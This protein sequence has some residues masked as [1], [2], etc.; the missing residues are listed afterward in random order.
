MSIRKRTWTTSTGKQREAFIV[1]YSFVKDGKRH[2]AIKTFDTEKAAKQF[3]GKVEQPHHKHGT[4]KGTVKEAA[5]KWLLAVEHGSRRNETELLEPATLRQYTYH[6]R[7]Y[8]EPQLGSERLNALTQETVT[9]FRDRL[10]RKLSRGMARKIIQTL[11]SIL[12]EADYHGNALDVKLGK[13]SKRHKEP[14]EPLTHREVGR[15]LAVL[16]AEQRPAWR[17]WRALYHDSHSHWT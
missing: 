17:R 6:V 16:D 12:L 10:L 4:A 7:R 15:V 1:D 9:R 14:I 13:D 11:K 8:I 5:D 3:R 2:R